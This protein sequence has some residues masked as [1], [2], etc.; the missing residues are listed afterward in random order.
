M[1]ARKD[2][3]HLPE[4]LSPKAMPKRRTALRA[5]ESTTLHMRQRG[6]R[7]TRKSRSRRRG[8]RER[9]FCEGTRVQTRLRNIHWTSD[10][11][12]WHAISLRTR[13]AT[14]QLQTVREQDKLIIKPYFVDHHA[15]QQNL[16]LQ[17]HALSNT[18]KTYV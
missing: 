12:G 9:Q 18:I 6:G 14:K 11:V 4:V 3:A 7:S 17:L 15:F 16:M 5:K 13:E 1:Y 8:Y 10:D 2:E